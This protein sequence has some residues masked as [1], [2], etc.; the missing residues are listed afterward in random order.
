MIASLVVAAI[1]VVACLVIEAFFSGSE[2][3]MVNAD[4]FKLIARAADG[5][6]GAARALELLAREDHLLA[7]CLIGTNLATVTGATIVVTSLGMLDLSLGVLGGLAYTPFTLVFGEALPKSIFQHHADR[8]APALAPALRAAQLVVAPAL[9]IVSVWSRLLDRMIGQSTD[10]PISREEIVDLLDDDGAN[11]IPDQDR[12]LIRRVFEISET[13]VVEVMTPLVDV[14]A[15]PADATVGEASALA[16][17]S[18]HS[19][20]PVFRDRIDNLIGYVR[21]GRLLFATDPNAGLDALVELVSFVPTSKRV[22]HLL[23]EMRQRRDQL[24]IVVDEY[25]GTVGIVTIED[26]LEEILGEIRDERDEEEPL[27]QRIGE[28]EWRVPA[29]AEIEEVVEALGYPLPEGEYETIAGCVLATMGRIPS[30]GE[31][32]RIGE[33][34]IIIEEATERAI[35]CVRVITPP[36]T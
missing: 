5:D 25:G 10:A 3:A 23:G 29:R 34:T 17:E 12:R 35:V 24:A 20:L 30:R 15:V 32:A 1:G 9:A 31:T 18:G 8:L 21:V 19:R 7:T 16:I 14:E 26:L 33:L 22:D 11:A 6:R 36:S 4:R 13:P 28:H 2:I 27:I